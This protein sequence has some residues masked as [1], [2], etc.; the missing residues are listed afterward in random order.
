MPEYFLRLHVGNP[1]G[2]VWPGAVSLRTS[3]N[4]TL[5]ANVV[6]AVNPVGFQ[7]PGVR[8]HVIIHQQLNHGEIVTGIQAGGG[9]AAGIAAHG[10]NPF[11][12]VVEQTILSL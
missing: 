5:M 12:P 7:N 6:L 11:W 4:R 10:R 9:A 2:T 3:A 1:N 8:V